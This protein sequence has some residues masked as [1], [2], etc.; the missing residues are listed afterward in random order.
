MMKMMK[1]TSQ[2]HSNTVTNIALKTVLFTEVNGKAINDTVMEF[3]YGR[4]VPDMKVSGRGTR[5]MVKGNS[6][7]LMVMFLT[8][9]GK[10]I[11]L[12]GMVF[13]HIL[14]ELNM[15]GIG[16]M[17][18]NMDMVLRRGKMG[19]GMKGIIKMEENM[20]KELMFGTMEVDM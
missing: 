11:K 13:I 2:S 1:M 20:V 16:K 12:M 5:L 17:I 15:K 4:T 19:L 18:C 8:G 9:N 7:M 10:T 14:M 6:G 3:R